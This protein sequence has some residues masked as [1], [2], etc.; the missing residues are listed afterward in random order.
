MERVVNIVGMGSSNLSVPDHG[1]NWGINVAYKN[2]SRMDKLFFFDDWAELMKD[3]ATLMP[4]GNTFTECVKGNPNIEIITRTEAKINAK[5][6]TYL[7]TT[8]MYPLNEATRLG[9]VGAFFTS[10]IAYIIIYTMIEIPSLKSRIEN[11]TKAVEVEQNQG[12]KE[13]FAKNLEMTK[14]KL[15]I[16]KPVDRIRLYGFE[17]WSGSDVTEYSYQRQCVEFWLAFAMGR[18]I[19]VELPY[20]CML[21]AMPSQ[22]L[23]GYMPFDAKKKG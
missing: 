21:A 3:D 13:I 1:E 8:S 20:V 19:K 11:L 18:G 2:C 7:T 23:Y 5:D 9:G 4:M 6:G 15:E 12:Q 14:S 16:V 10:T 17:L 22:S